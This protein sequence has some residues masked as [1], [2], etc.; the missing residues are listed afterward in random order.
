M[1]ISSVSSTT[2]NQYSTV[3]SNDEIT[4]LE[5]QKS[6]LQKELLSVS[7]SDDDAETK[8]LKSKQIQLQIQQI[9]ARIQ[10]LKAEKNKQSQSQGNKTLSEKALDT[11]KIDV[12][13]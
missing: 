11:Q 5:K 12:K 8:E 7:R 4:K 1:N 9:E 13:I 2:S 10:Q 6:V 3:S